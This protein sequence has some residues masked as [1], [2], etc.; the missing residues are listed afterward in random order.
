MVVACQVGIHLV[1][2]PTASLPS[3]QRI[4]FTFQWTEAGNWE[5]KNFGV[6]VE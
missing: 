3:Q 6:T 5:G 1:D 4:D 2:L